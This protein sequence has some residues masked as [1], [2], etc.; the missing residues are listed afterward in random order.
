[1]PGGVPG[2]GSLRSL[3]TVGGFVAL[4]HA[5]L[6]ELVR[7]PGIAYQVFQRVNRHA[8]DPWQLIEG[9]V[10]LQLNKCVADGLVDVSEGADGRRVYRITR[11]GRGELKA[12]GRQGEAPLEPRRDDLMLKAAYLWRD[13]E[14]AVL[15]SLQGRRRD[16]ARLLHIL[17]RSLAEPAPAGEDP[18]L[19]R[20]GVER[21]RREAEAELDWVE[22]CH[23]RLVSLWGEAGNFTLDSGTEPR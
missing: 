15:M 9:A 21:S 5:V 17:T 8:G 23:D 18:E 1:M 20:L 11:S 22:A 4:R 14:P 19:W 16:L 12:W 3:P 7:G 6:A 10:R 2:G 13:P